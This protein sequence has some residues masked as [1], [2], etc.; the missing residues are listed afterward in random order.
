MD[1]AKTKGLITK[2]GDTV[3]IE[4]KKECLI[5]ILDG[6]IFN[7]GN[8]TLKEK[9]NKFPEPDKKALF[10][11]GTLLRLPETFRSPFVQPMVKNALENKITNNADLQNYFKSH[12]TGFLGA[13]EGGAERL[14][15]HT[16]KVDETANN[17]ASKLIDI[18]SQHLQTGEPVTMTR[19]EWESIKQDVDNNIQSSRM[20]TK[21][22]SSIVADL[23][24]PQ[25]NQLS[26]I[27]RI[28]FGDLVHSP[29]FPSA[30]APV[31]VKN[32]HVLKKDWDS[33]ISTKKRQ[34]ID[35]KKKEKDTRE[36]T[37]EEDKSGASEAFA[38][39]GY[40]EEGRSQ[41]DGEWSYASKDFSD[42]ENGEQDGDSGEA[43]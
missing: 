14:R 27:G 5:S 41:E 21:A 9:L 37:D 11:L 8:E 6:S 4:D 23:F 1:T 33:S 35:A 18:R 39:D 24:N 2:L 31:D 20:G 7:A 13:N 16:K 29:P 32:K 43:S 42:D 25:Q 17:T 19:S 12:E 36:A 40:S 38:E 26:S 34:K 15:V 30:S 28:A 22:Y 10:N 3:S